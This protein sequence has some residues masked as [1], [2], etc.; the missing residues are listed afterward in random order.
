MTYVGDGSTIGTCIGIS[1]RAYEVCSE[2]DGQL[3]W[4]CS[5]CLANLKSLHSCM[6]KLALENHTLKLEVAQLRTL[7]GVVANLSKE[8][9]SDLAFVT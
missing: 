7:D 8:V 6:D 3:P 5:S 2:F 9:N 1:E 4:F